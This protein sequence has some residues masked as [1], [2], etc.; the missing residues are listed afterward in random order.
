[1]KIFCS[2][3]EKCVDT[4]STPEHLVQTNEPMVMF[5]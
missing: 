1:M 5:T 2:G 4:Y 3:N